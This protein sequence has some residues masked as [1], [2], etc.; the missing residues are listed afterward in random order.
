MVQSVFDITIDFEKSHGSY[1]F[2]KKSNNQFLDLFS[3][4]SS[5]PLGYNHSIFDESFDQ[6]I[7]PISYLRMSNNLFHSD[8]LN[9]FENK[10]KTISFHNNLHFCS[11]GALAVEAALKCAF[12]YAKDPNSI[13]VGAKNSF[14]GINGWGFVTDNDLVSVTHRVEDY[15]RNDW[16]NIELTM[17]ASYISDNINKISSVII[18]PIQCTAGDVHLDASI[19]KNIESVCKQNDICFIV[20][21]IQTGFGTTGQMWYSKKIGLDPDIIVFGKKSQICGVMVNDKYSEAIH[22]QYRK[23]EVTFDGELIDAVRGEYIL[24]AIE[25]YSLLERVKKNSIILHNELSEAYDNYRSVGH[26]IAFD[27]KNKNERDKLVE[28]AY[29]NRLLLNPTGEKSIRVRPNLA[30]SNNELD[31]FLVKLKSSNL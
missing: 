4:F 5:L 24:N 28:K 17:M 26:L 3:M 25:K 13:V 20:D 29:S 1:V 22:S 27:C 16:K 6:K 8:E 2:D 31:E 7:R 15:P 10:F 14:H 30:F 21:E 23:L 18:E 12:T 9:S 19:L 11:T